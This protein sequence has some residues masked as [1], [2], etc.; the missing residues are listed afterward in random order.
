MTITF[1]M[2]ITKPCYVGGC[3]VIQQRNT[4]NFH[5]LVVIL[6]NE[7]IMHQTLKEKLEW[8][9]PYYFLKLTVSIITPATILGHGA[10]SVR[11]KCLSF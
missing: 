9:S 6:N 2:F 3:F 8:T 7:G 4:T 5:S 1:W 10:I 11:E